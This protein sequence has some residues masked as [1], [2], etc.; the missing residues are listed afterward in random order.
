MSFTEFECIPPILREKQEASSLKFESN[1]LLPCKYAN[2]ISF[3]KHQYLHFKFQSQETYFLPALNCPLWICFIKSLLVRQ[4]SKSVYKSH[5]CKS[6]N[7]KF[8]S[9]TRITVFLL[10]NKLTHPCSVIPLMIFT[11]WI[12][13]QNLVLYF[14][15]LLMFSMTPSAWTWIQDRV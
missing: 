6:A 14:C 8:S 2:S 15:S 7:E 9:D 1:C 4:A 12:S 5:F 10:W 3:P 11:L 13:L